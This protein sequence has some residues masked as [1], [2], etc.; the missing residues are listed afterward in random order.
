MYTS[1]LKFTRMQI[2]SLSRIVWLQLLCIILYLVFFSQLNADNDLANII[3]YAVGL[4]MLSY[5]M[6]RIFAF[7]DAKYKTKL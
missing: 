6:I 2:S 7:T 1:F 4:L 5:L 3:I